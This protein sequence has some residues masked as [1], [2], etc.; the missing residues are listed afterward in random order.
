MLILVDVG[1]CYSIGEEI[2]SDGEGCRQPWD[3]QTDSHAWESEE[4]GTPL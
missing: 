4:H 3:P 1:R 2:S